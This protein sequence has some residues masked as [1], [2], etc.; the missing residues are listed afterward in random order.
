MKMVQ[1]PQH[2]GDDR[3]ASVR[4]TDSAAS[5]LGPCGSVTPTRHEP[6]GMEGKHVRPSSSASA[7]SSGGSSGALSGDA[8]GGRQVRSFIA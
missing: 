2:D 5:S 7:A 4:S 1:T 6:Y 3:R 8:D